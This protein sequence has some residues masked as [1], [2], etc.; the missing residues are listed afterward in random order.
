MFACDGGLER[1]EDGVGVREPGTKD[2]AREQLERSRCS[3]MKRSSSAHAL[4]RWWGK[5]IGSILGTRKTES[6]KS[7]CWM[8]ALSMCSASTGAAAAVVA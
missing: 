1:V 4:A 7:P 3:E 2:V 6:R 8:R 5:S